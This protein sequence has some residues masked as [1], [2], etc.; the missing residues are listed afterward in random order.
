MNRLL[1]LLLISTL[2][3]HTKNILADPRCSLMIDERK[4]GDPLEGGP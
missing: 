3:I 2:A 4:S 1:Y